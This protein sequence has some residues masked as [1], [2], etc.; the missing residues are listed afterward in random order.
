MHPADG[1]FS[2]LGLNYTT[3][4]GATNLIGVHTEGVYGRVSGDTHAVMGMKLFAEYIDGIAVV[5]FGS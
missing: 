2:Q 3:G 4:S 1:D 5:T